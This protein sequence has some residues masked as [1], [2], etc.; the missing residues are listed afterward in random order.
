MTAQIVDS[1][2]RRFFSHAKCQ[3]MIVRDFLRVGS[4]RTERD[5]WMIAAAH[6]FCYRKVSAITPILR[7]AVKSGR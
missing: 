4:K 5:M 3:R 1:G 7:V 2:K 6:L